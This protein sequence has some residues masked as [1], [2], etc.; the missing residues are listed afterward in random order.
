MSKE[1]KVI[2]GVPQGT[3]YGPLLFLVYINDMAKLVSPGTHIRLFADDTILYRELA[4][5]ED[6]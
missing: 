2:S 5:I 4:S 6:Q 1:E 3:V